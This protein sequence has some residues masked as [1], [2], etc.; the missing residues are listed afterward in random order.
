[1][2]QLQLRVLSKQA[3]TQSPAASVSHYLEITTAIASSN[4]TRNSDQRK[5]VVSKHSSGI[6]GAGSEDIA[7]FSD[8]SNDLQIPL[9]KRRRVAEAPLQAL[10]PTP[11]PPSEPSRQSDSSALSA[12]MMGRDETRSSLY[13]IG[14]LLHAKLGRLLGEVSCFNS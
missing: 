8:D 1:M 3:Y 12:R 9:S 13:V 2:W 7:D 6:T 11:A 4:N 14:K 5:Q 10:V